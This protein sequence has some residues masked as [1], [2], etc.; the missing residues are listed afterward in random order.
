MWLL[1][2]R[3]VRA[4]SLRRKRQPESRKH[5]TGV[6]ADEQTFQPSPLPFIV[7]VRTQGL[8]R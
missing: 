4:S 2:L 5:L 7:V 6:C 3:A 8:R 1:A